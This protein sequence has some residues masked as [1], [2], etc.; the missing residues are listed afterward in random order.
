MKKF[1]LP[2]H[3]TYAVLLMFLTGMLS[4][5]VA[6]F[7]ETAAYWMRYGKKDAMHKTNHH[8]KRD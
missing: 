8:L 2:R 6:I 4:S 5:F 7:V 1:K 3:A